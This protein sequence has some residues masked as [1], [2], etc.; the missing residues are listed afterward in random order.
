[1]TVHVLPGDSLVE[2][3]R[4]TKLDGDMI[5]CREALISGD[6]DA[7]S[8]PEFWDQRARFISTAYSED[9]I[10]Y[11]EK[12]ADELARLLD[13]DEGTE[14]NL[15]FEYELFC[16]VNMWFCL[17]LLKETGAEIYRVEPSVLKTED[18]WKGFGR[19][20]ADDLQKCFDGRKKLTSDD[21]ILGANLWNAYR[22][23]D[24]TRLRELSNTHSAAFPYLKEVC[25]AAID[26][27]VR[28]LEILQ[29]IRADGFETFP[30]I[31]P[32]FVDRAGEY[33]F[34]DVQIKYLLEKIT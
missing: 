10:E 6:V 20:D 5:V 7:G 27:D 23:N 31:F 26:K 29:K 15:W 32:E 19:L 18:R 34:G 16:S 28:P 25:Q 11:H 9:A 8:L 22:R 4:K 24:H 2:E 3:F 33:G 21:I 13:L 14:V 1:M 30:E 12:V 17:W